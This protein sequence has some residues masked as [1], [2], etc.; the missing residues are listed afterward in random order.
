[1]ELKAIFLNEHGL[2]Y[3]RERANSILGTGIEYVVA[4]AEIGGS[5]SSVSL[6]EDGVVLGEFN[7]VMFNF[8]Y[9]G[10]PYNIINDPLRLPCIEHAYL[11]QLGIKI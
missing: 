10:K 4:N 6:H 2:D 1:M 9:D 7:S 11:A 3:E 8:Y 5:S